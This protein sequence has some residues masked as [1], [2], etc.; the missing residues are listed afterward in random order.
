MDTFEFRQRMNSGVDD[1]TEELAKSVLGAA[2]E[3]HTRLKPR[4]PESVYKAALSHELTLRAIPHECE[5]P[6]PIL[7]KGIKVGSGFVDILVDGRLI[8]E[9][10]AVEPLSPVHHAQVIGYLQGLDLQLGLL[11]N[12]NVTRPGSGIKRVINSYLNLHP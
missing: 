5:Y 12:F 1:R 10:K 9:L 3:V 8:L 6:V 7:Y 11:I 4:L 2:I